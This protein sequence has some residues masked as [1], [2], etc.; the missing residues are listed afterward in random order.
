MAD[1]IKIPKKGTVEYEKFVKARKKAREDLQQ[2]EFKVVV[3]KVKKKYSKEELLEIVQIQPF[4]HELAEFSAARRALDQLKVKYPM[5]FKV[6]CEERDMNAGFGK[7][8]VE[9]P[10]EKK[11]SEKEA[12]DLSKDEQVA[13]IKKLDPEAE[14][15]GLEKDRVALILKLQ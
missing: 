12:V 2:K 11:L 15:P 1:Q 14:I 5:T 3:D 9:K 10:V 4:G 13:L 6:Q 8:R 7:V